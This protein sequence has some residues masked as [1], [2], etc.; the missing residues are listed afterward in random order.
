MTNRHSFH[1]GLKT[2]QQA[3]ESQLFKFKRHDSYCFHSSFI[4][5][6]SHAR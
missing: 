3:E 4:Q 6:V 5:E 1:L 2:P